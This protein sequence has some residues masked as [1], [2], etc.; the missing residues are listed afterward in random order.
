VKKQESLPGKES[1]ALLGRDSR[2]FTGTGLRPVTEL[3]IILR[4][5]LWA[6]AA[7]EA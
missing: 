6:W 1:Q 5:G 7:W 4:S 2:F 3:I